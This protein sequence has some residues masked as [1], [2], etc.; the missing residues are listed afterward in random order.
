MN[1]KSDRSTTQAWLK[2]QEPHKHPL[3]VPFTFFMNYMSLCGSIKNYL[4]LVNTLEKMT[5]FSSMYHK[6]LD[7]SNKGQNYISLIFQNNWHFWSTCVLLST[8]NPPKETKQT[9]LPSTPETLSSPAR[10][11]WL[12]LYSLAQLENRRQKHNKKGKCLWLNCGI[13]LKNGKRWKHAALP[14][15]LAKAGTQ[16]TLEADSKI[17]GNPTCQ[18]AAFQWWLV[19]LISRV[20]KVNQCCAV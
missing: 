14:V 4:K 7:Q 19:S 1:L 2:G 10:W 5:E 18:K 17:A 8:S 13:K 9:K 20:Y 12:W 3:Y 15:R 11:Q 16:M 6:L